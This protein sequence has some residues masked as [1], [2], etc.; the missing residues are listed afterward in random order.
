MADLITVGTATRLVAK[1]AAGLLAQSA[2]NRIL[3]QRASTGRKIVL[4]IPAIWG[5]SA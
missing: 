5:I 2:A 3:L 4:R 1:G